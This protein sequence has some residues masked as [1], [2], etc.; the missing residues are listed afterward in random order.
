ME[1][2]GTS[3]D[4]VY[5]PLVELMYQGCTSGRAYVPYIYSHARWELPQVIQ[6]FVVEFVWCLPGI[7]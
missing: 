6:V 1:F 7:N 5:V 3:S 2:R 4:G